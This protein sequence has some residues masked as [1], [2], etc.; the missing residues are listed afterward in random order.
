MT[1]LLIASTQRLSGGTPADFTIAKDRPIET[2]DWEVVYAQIP[3]ATHNVS[4]GTVTVSV[5]L[6]ADQSASITPAFYTASTFASHLQ[7]VLQ[8]LDASFACSFDATSAQLTITHASSAFTLVGDA[9]LNR[10]LSISGVQTSATVSGTETVY[11]GILNLATLG[12]YHVTMGDGAGVRTTAGRYSSFIVPVEDD[13]LEISCYKNGSWG[14]QRVHFRHSTNRL[15][16]TVTDE[17][18]SLLTL[19]H[20]WYVL[21]RRV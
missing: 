10:H 16:V 19:P 20:D 2:G 17:D 12:A 9:A 4:S 13:T 1:T 15:H 3:N 7:T 8:S 11:S 6:G 18:G 14:P 5:G 21:L